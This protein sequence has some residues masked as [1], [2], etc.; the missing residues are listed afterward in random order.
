MEKSKNT[1]KKNKGKTEKTTNANL[2]RKCAPIFQSINQSTQQNV[3]QQPH[4]SSN[5]NKV[6][7]WVVEDFPD[8]S[9]KLCVFLSNPAPS[10]MCGRKEP[11]F[12]L[13][14]PPAPI[15]VHPYPFF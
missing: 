11:M 8:A 4:L 15:V 1:K 7:L 2:F 12:S 3:S 13:Q 5:H 10:L 14:P 6:I 9:L